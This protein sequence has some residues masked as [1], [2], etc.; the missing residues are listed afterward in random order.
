M[1][2]LEIGCIVQCRWRDE[3]QKCEVIDVR[4]GLSPGTYDYY[5]HYIEF[6]RRLDEWVSEDRLNLDTV[7]EKGEGKMEK[8]KEVRGEADSR[9][10]T[11]HWKRQIGEIDHVQKGQE[12]AKL[13]ALEKSMKKSPK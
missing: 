7:E 9:K 12:D 3:Y 8:E 10:I 1:T 11:R 6:N 2:K 13:A 5:V 4:D